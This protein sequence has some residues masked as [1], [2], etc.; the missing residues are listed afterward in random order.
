VSD[1]GKPVEGEVVDGVPG[2]A[3][4]FY[5][6]LSGIVILG[7]DWICFGADL[8]SGFAALAVMSF[9]ASA[10]TFWAV[11]R[12]QTSMRGD[13]PRAAALKALLGAIAAGVPFPVTGTIVGGI[14]LALAGLPRGK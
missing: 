5:H 14:I 7:F 4:A 6:P 1:D 12:I 2:P 10:G 11:Y 8:F 3:K 9:V 13:H